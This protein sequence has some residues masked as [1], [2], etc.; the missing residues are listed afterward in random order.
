MRSMIKEKKFLGTS[1]EEII[2]DWHAF[3]D[4]QRQESLVHYEY[5][6]TAFG[7]LDL[8]GIDRS[9]LRSE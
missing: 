2:A 5:S 1:V 9:N 8:G 7:G 3:S 4:A 6:Y